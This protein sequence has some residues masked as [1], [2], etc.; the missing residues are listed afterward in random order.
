MESSG[1]YNQNQFIV[2]VNTKV[3]P[4]VSLFGF[5]VLNRALSNTDGIGTSPPNPYNFSGEYGPASTDVRHHITAGGSIA[6]RWSVRVSPYLVA[7]SGAPFDITTG[8]DLYG[9]TLFNSRPGFANNPLKPGLIATSYGLLDPD[10]DAAETL[11]PRNYGRGPALIAV[12]LRVGKAFGF[13]PLKESA[14]KPAQGSPGPAP[15]GP[16]TKQ[17]LRGLLGSPS[18]ARRY[19]LSVS[20][21]IRNLLNH[22]NPGPIVG[23]I[24]SPL[25]G[26]S[27]QIAGAPNGEG[28]FETANNRRLE[29][30]IR[31][32][33]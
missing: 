31:L 18:T 6:L 5:Y 17:G 4:A 10:P 29:L 23:D 11:V 22:N 32:T 14:A 26:R 8:S 24:T 2:N 30:Q 12:N 33:F 1:L 19:N 3:K 28:F 9:T 27:N 25:F 13:G 20:M 16:M 15:L 21:S 7:Q